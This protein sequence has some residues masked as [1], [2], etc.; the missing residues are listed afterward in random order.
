MKSKRYEPP[1][2]AAFFIFLL[3]YLGSKYSP[4]RPVL[5]H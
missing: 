2:Y 5:R 4:Q 3:L 1:H